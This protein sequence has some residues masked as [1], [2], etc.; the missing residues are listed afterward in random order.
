VNELRSKLPME[1]GIAFMVLPM[2]ACKPRFH[3]MEILMLGKKQT[4]LH[5]RQISKAAEISPSIRALSFS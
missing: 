1:H 3:T 2:A 5:R 4:L